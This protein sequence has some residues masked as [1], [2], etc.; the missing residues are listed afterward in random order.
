MRKGE[1]ITDAELLLMGVL[2]GVNRDLCCA[3]VERSGG[4]EIKHGSVYVLMQR[5]ERKGFVTSRQA[6]EPPD[7]P[8]IPRRLYRPTPTGVSEARRIV[9]DRLRDVRVTYDRLMRKR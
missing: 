5:L 7:R 8:G 4:V 2:V 3:D 1:R 6:K 9:T